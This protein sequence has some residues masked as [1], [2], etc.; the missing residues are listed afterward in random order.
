M[1]YHE[2]GMKNVISINK[3]LDPIRNITTGRYILHITFSAYYRIN[4]LQGKNYLIGFGILRL[5]IQLN[6]LHFDTLI[7]I[8]FECFVHFIVA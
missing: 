3:K 2:I 1:L 7:T 4:K 8:N 6:K 5:M